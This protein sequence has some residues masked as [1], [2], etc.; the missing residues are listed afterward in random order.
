MPIAHRTAA[1]ATAALAL[2]TAVAAQAAAPTVAGLRKTTRPIWTVYTK[3]HVAE[4]AGRKQWIRIAFTHDPKAV[5]YTVKGTAGTVSAPGIRKVSAPAATEAAAK[6]ATWL[7]QRK[8]TLV[9]HFTWK[10]DRWE[11][12]TV[13]WKDVR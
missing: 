12:G 11:P 9:L 2:L 13:E 5:R 7:Q 8:A 1:R 10:K 6:A 3:D 4:L